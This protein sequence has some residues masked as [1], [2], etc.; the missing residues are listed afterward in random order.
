MRPANQWTLGPLRDRTKSWILRDL[1]RMLDARMRLG[2]AEVEWRRALEEGRWNA[3]A[4]FEYIASPPLV[5]LKTA[6]LHDLL[7]F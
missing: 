2:R 3:D 1:T 6:L 7:K 4:V 5:S